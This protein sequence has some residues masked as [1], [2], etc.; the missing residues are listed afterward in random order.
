METL[1]AVRMGKEL[2]VAA[3]KGNIEFLREAQNDES[4]L[5]KTHEQN[6]AIHIAT[7]HEQYEFIEAFLKKFPN[8]IEL[9][10]EKNSKG[11]TPL[12]IA[13]EVGNLNVVSQLYTFLES[14]GA[15]DESGDDNNKP[16]KWKNLKGNTA[17]HVALIH[18]N[19][20]IG[21]FLLEKDSDLAYIVNESKEAP[22]HLAIKHHSESIV[23][24]IKQLHLFNEG[25]QVNSNVKFV[26]EED[27]SSVINFLVEKGSCVTCWGDANGLTPLH[28]A[29][30]LSIPYHLQV[31]RFI[32]YHCPESSEVCDGSG[33]SILHLLINRMPSYQEA[34]SLLSFKEIS[35]L[36]NYQDQQG[37]TPLHIAARNM[38]ISMVRALL[39]LPSKL[40]IKNIHGI[41]VLAKRAMTKEESEAINRANITYLRERMSKLGKIDFLLSQDSKRRNI[42]HLLL[43]IKNES[44]IMQ[45]DF[46][47]FIQQVLEGFPALVCQTD[48]NGDTPIHILVRNNPNTIVYVASGNR[49]N[50]QQKSDDPVSSSLRQTGLLSMILEMCI[51]H[52]PR[53]QPEERINGAQYI[54]PWLVQNADGNAPLH[55]GIIAKN[56]KLVQK[57]FS[58]NKKSVD[59]VN[60]CMET[61]L[62]LVAKHYIDSE[63]FNR[64][65]IESMVEANVSAAEWFDKDGLTPILRAFEAGNLSTATILCSVCPEAAGI[66][67]ADG[68][69]IWHMLVKQPS[70][71]YLFHLIKNSTNLRHLLKWKDKNGNTPLHLAIEGKRF[72]LV[73]VFLQIWGDERGSLKGKDQWL[74]ELLK[75]QNKEGVRSMWGIPTSQMET[76]V[77][78]MGIIA[79]LLTTITFTAAFTVPGG[80]FENIGTPIMIKK[81]AFQVFMISDVVAMCL[82]MMV[83]V[84]L[85][86]IMATNN[87][88]HSVMILDFSITLLLAS[89]YATLVTFM[90][91]LFATMFTL[92][93]WIAIVALVLCSL[94]ILFIHKCLVINI[95]IPFTNA[96]LFFFWKFLG[97]DIESMVEANVSAAEWFDKD[98][99][100][101]I[102]RA[103]EAGNLSTAT[104]LCSVC[105]EAAGIRDA[106]GKNI[107][108]MLVKQPSDYYLFHLIKNSTNLRHLLKWKDKNENTPLHLEIEGKRFDLV[109]VF[110]QIWGDERGSLKGKDQWL[111]ELLKIQ[112]KEGVRSMWG[113]PTSQMKT[114]VNTMGVIAALL[115]IITF[116]TAFTV[117]GGLF[118]DIGTPIMIKKAACYEV[119]E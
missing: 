89:F 82:S 58:H 71:Y 116:T 46:V 70:D 86:W 68:K 39:K 41:S 44:H 97:K 4:L 118:E 113:I 95:L 67:D 87:R 12:H 9:I 26:P 14:I 7:R 88:H 52:T 112:N 6:N 90:T 57:M 61:P 101:P 36:R 5:R 22:L 100:T 27:M 21:R 80:L 109:Q 43:E 32:L 50:T 92:K 84:C 40:S 96:A 17:V 81:A 108:H 3:M 8:N 2:Y 29:A 31:I 30:A 60:K 34:K 83:L 117:P 63:P 53:M 23:S 1:E 99:L 111:V 28:R 115:T 103:F 79:A 59:L 69:N 91:G 77:N 16:W 72:D 98:G 35:A 105:P 75:I 64:K 73:Q 93:P 106:D 119:V 42:L 104:I 38:D 65:D 11:N 37:D 10:C 78:T 62:H 47:D 74:V 66:R 13:A 18:C 20:K 56:Y 85:L 110:L 33:N 76:Y 55:Q 49:D 94:L 25:G 51:Q 114:Y 48:S 54:Q 24:R 19:V 15:D 45:D 107:W 102:L